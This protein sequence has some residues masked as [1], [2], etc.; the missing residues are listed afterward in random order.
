MENLKTRRSLLKKGA[1]ISFGLPLI[2]LSPAFKNIVA[3]TRYMDEI[4]IQLYTVRNQL[5]ENPEKTLKSIASLGYK[6]VELMDIAKA[7]EITPHAKDLGLMVK[8]SFFQ[9]THLTGRWDLAEKYGLPKQTEGYNFDRILDDAEALG[10]KH[11]VFGYILPEERSTMDDYKKITEKLNHSG[12]L[13]KKRG[14]QLCYHNHSFEFGPI[15]GEI[16]YEYLIENFD[17]DLV[18]FELDVFWASLGGFDPVALMDR[19]DK[20]ISQLHLKDKLKGTPVIFAEQEVP[21][22]A[23]KELGNGVVDIRTILRKAEKI[24][25]QECHV[26]QDHSPN[27]VNSI[28][29]S[30]SYLKGI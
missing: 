19:L 7:G 21:H 16:P 24:G 8:S 3:K 18:K 26:E 17:K 9:W 30:I 6:Q 27:P 28:S 11:L 25:V 13:C 29:Q 1:A 2:G 4:G 20:R 14:I 23:F 10:L 12:E 5:A 15:E 22:E